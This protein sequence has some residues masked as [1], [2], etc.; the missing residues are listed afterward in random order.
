VHIGFWWKN[1]KGRD[2]SEDLGVDGRIILEW[3][4]KQWEGVKTWTGL[5]WLRI[6]TG[7]GLL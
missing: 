2:Q 3:I 6:G 7:G 5:I 1:P 4:S